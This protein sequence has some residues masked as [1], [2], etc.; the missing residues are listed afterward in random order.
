M[1][2]NYLCPTYQGLRPG[3]KSNDYPG[4]GFKNSNKNDYKAKTSPNL[5]VTGVWG[6]TTWET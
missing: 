5:R 3:A 6:W 1:A 4:F 2:R